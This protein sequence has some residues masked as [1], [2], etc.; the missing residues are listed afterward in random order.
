ML[1]QNKNQDI[2]LFVA[3]RKIYFAMFIVARLT[4]F[5]D[6]KCVLLCDKS[7]ESVEYIQGFIEQRLFDDLLFFDLRLRKSKEIKSF[8]EKLTSEFLEKYIAN[9]YDEEFYKS[10]YS[11]NNFS[12]VVTCSDVDDYD[13]D[14]FLNIKNKSYI[15]LEFTANQFDRRSKRLDNANF[16]L[17]NAYKDLMVKYQAFNGRSQNC[18]P[19]FHPDTSKFPVTEIYYKFFF[20][21]ELR[22]L[23][24][25]YIK[26]IF[27]AYKHKFE[28]P[29]NSKSNVLFLLHSVASHKNA[30]RDNPAEGHVIASKKGKSIY[31]AVNQLAIDYLTDPE[32]RLFLKNHPSDPF[33][34]KE[35]IENYNSALSITDIPGEFLAMDPI[36]KNFDWN[37][38]IEYSAGHYN[39]V[40]GTTQNYKITRNFARCSFFYHRIYFALKILGNFKF[41]NL[42][43]CEFSVDAIAPLITKHFY[44]KGYS[45]S[46]VQNLAKSVQSNLEGDVYLIKDWASILSNKEILENSENIYVILNSETIP[47]IQGF[48]TTKF[49]ITKEILKNKGRF[50]NLNSEYFYIM[51]KSNNDYA[52]FNL[53]KR[54]EI[55][56]IIV[57]CEV[58]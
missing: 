15:F 21:E 14:I 50:L 12:Y 43:L 40:I 33:N 58:D 55:A 1:L 25:D 9:S 28:I 4:L 19:M 17:N 37:S 16:S 44:E 5:R 51:S 20:K 27:L 13:F 52:N 32:D 38:T 47:F 22:R 41:Y 35:I 10:K 54:L 42:L 56:G 57:R 11:L 7:F 36:Y 29:D 45:L 53:E 6:K 2:V 8:G 34:Q 48:N 18:T 26:K 23:D 31:N 3:S 49:T 24:E 30:N 39:S 46:K